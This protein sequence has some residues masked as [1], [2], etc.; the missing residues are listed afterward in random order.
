[1]KTQSVARADYGCQLFGVLPKRKISLSKLSH[2]CR[3][4]RYLN[5]INKILG[6]L[7]AVASHPVNRHRKFKAVMEYG[8]IQI[9]ARLVPGDVCVEF[10]NHTRLLVSPRI[11][12]AA[13]YLAPRL[14]EFEEMTFVSHFLRPDET[15]VDVGANIGAFTILAVGVAHARAIA[16]EPSPD[17]FNLLE[18]NIRLNDF[19]NSVRAVSA[20]VGRNN[21]EVQFSMGLGTENH[22]VVGDAANGSQKV[23]MTTLDEELAGQPPDLLK[24]DVE[25][26][27]TEMFAGAASTLRHSRLQAIIVERNNL[28][29]RYGFN[30]E[31]LHHEIRRNGFIPCNYKPFSRELIHV[32]NET[33][34]N[35]IYVRDFAAANV[36]LRTAPPLTLGDLSV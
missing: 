28:G 10:P 3:I 4:T 20:A 27:E 15:F 17:T 6:A 7:R 32:S 19:Q 26:F 22:I 16:F 5:P 11:K 1:L 12:G 8:F 2:C 36:R 34:G 14:C 31:A 23:K 24:V 9:A 33:T 30:E 21:G 18:Q 25:G 13:H 35:I 29:A